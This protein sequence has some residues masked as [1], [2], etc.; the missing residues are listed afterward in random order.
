M[1]Q[2][3]ALVIGISNYHRS[4]GN[5]TK[6]ATDAQA[7]ARCLREHG[8]FQVTLLTE[9]LALETMRQALKQFL[10]EQATDNDALI[11]F[12]G[13]G[14]LLEST[15]GYRETFLSASDTEIVR[16]P[17]K[18][19][20]PLY[21]LPFGELNSL[22]QQSSLSSLVLLLDC[23][24]SGDMLER[25]PVERALT[26]FNS[27]QRNYCFITACRSFEASRA[28]RSDDH[29][30]FTGALL[31]AL[32]PP[33]R[34]EDDRSITSGLL[35]YRLSQSLKGSGQEA[36]HLG[37][38]NDIAIATYPALPKD[39][40]EPALNPANPYIGLA[41]F[42]AST[43]D[44][45]HGRASAIRALQARLL[46]CRV[47]TVFGPSGCGKSSLVKAGLL[48][49]LR[50]RPFESATWQVEMLT[51]TAQPLE[52]LGDRLKQRSQSTAPFILFIDQFEELFTLCDSEADQRSF[53]QLMTTAIG[54]LNHL[55]RIV[56]AIRGDFLDNCAKIPESATL[57]N[58]E[59]EL[60]TYMVTHLS[61]QEMAEAIERP[62][63]QQGARFE[64]GL[65]PQI[66]ADVG[67]EPGALPL[68]QYAL[69]QLW[70]LCIQPDSPP[71]LTFQGYEQIGGVQGA[72]KQRADQLY[73][74]LHPDD[75]GFTRQLLMELVQ[76][77]EGQEV[78]R[79]KA[80]WEKLRAIAPYTQLMRVVE[81]LTQERLIVTDEKTVEVAHEALLS[82]WTLLK[83][84]IEENR[85]NIRLSRR[86][87][88]DC[89]DW[90]EKA[91]SEAYLLS[92]G[93]LAA[94]QEWV[95]KEQP[96]LTSLEQEFLHQSIQKRD[97]ETQSQL[98]Q[99]RK[100]REEAEGRAIAEAA[101]ANI[102]SAKTKI[103]RQKIR[104]SLAAML[105]FVGV[106]ILSIN[107]KQQADQR[108]KAVINAL[109]VGPQHLFNSGKQIESLVASI[110]VYKQLEN[111]QEKPPLELKEIV[112][113]I[114]EFNRIEGHSKEVMSIN[115]SQDGN[116]IVSSSR[117]NSVKVW[118]KNGKFVKELNYKSDYGVFDAVFS[119]NGKFIASAD[120]NGI[121]KLWNLQTGQVKD[122]RSKDLKESEYATK[123]TFS[124]KDNLVAVSINSDSNTGSVKVWDIA[125][126]KLVKE[127]TNP[128][129]LP[130]IFS[131]SFS[132]VSN[133]LVICDDSGFV[134]LWN[135][136]TGKVKVWSGHKGLIRSI[137]FKPSG[138]IFA[139]AGSDKLIKIW[140]TSD[141]KLLKVMPGHS[142]E[143]TE[144]IFSPDGMKIA[145]ASKDETIKLWDVNNGIFLETFI[146]HSDTVGGVSFNP[147]GS[148]LASAGDDKTIRLWYVENPIKTQS[149]DSK[150]LVKYGCKSLKGYLENNH[151]LSLKDRKICDKS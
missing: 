105:L 48:P 149:N 138:E 54:T 136:V 28:K 91:Q 69:T 108:K 145:S 100:L 87:E 99:E 135:I 21:S 36:L 112:F 41:S 26:A 122:L 32:S 72:L 83:T 8:G 52:N 120:T 74:S 95:E 22:I 66:I 40:S 16:Q 90:Q 129:K 15:T 71:I 109:T 68:L 6:P 151:K 33:T 92:A 31:Q 58:R 13:H 80:H 88:T 77:G 45:F 139:T 125:N 14:I 130:R 64:L 25:D 103:E 39:T 93:R 34:P 137:A 60:T 37:W 53:I 38:G 7:V 97:R 29:S 4:L 82:E 107:L 78:T 11:Y 2:R 118:T 12:T 111:L 140:R 126:Y 85:D 46:N 134:K 17:S 124:P 132:P 84:W 10:L 86:L 116:Y 114:R 50:D 55:K 51:P 141:G 128:G 42:D 9:T 70:D 119:R 5:L 20:E 133:I 43:A 127:F 47:L 49:E 79:R 123:V 142:D 144:I 101:R 1:A 113:N 117:D 143:V 121:L 150:A 131:I 110:K 44:Y 30:L 57:I 98:D 81:R 89:H 56:I 96:N 18:P 73:R 102:E 94:V 63:A 146:G 62:V 67:N 35:F 59:T 23:C 148:V 76:L 27:T 106:S 104:W 115:F 65:V 147:D 61:A 3:Y 75:Q 24:H 19:M